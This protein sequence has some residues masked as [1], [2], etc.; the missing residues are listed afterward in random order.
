MSIY[1][2]KKQ[3]IIKM[4]DE[5]LKEYTN[6]LSKSMKYTSDIANVINSNNI[7]Q[8]EVLDF[9]K[10]MFNNNDSDKLTRLCVA[11]QYV[12][13]PSDTEVIDALIENIELNKSNSTQKF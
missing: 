5:L 4:K 7:S 9:M 13:N 8:I 1:N 11:L 2:E 10:F 12:E 3:K 6:L